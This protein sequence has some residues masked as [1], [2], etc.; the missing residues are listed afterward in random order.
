MHCACVLVFSL[1]LQLHHLRHCCC[2]VVVVC[3]CCLFLLLSFSLPLQL[4]H[5]RHCCCRVVVVCVC[6]L[7]LLLSFSLPLQLH[8]LRHSHQ[9]QSVGEE[10]LL[11]TGTFGRRGNTH[12]HHGNGLSSIRVDGRRR[13]EGK[14]EG[15]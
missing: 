12:L 7:F 11:Q 5:L 6:C 3:V 4:H 15:G 13:R 14:G 1:P 10:R 2:R 9:E 8:H